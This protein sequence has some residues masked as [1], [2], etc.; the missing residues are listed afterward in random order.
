MDL[1]N[2]VFEKC[3]FDPRKHSFVKDIEAALPSFKEYKN[4]KDRTNPV[5]I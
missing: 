1:N 5:F 4:N 2:F 3:L